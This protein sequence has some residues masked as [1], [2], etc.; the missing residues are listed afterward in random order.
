MFKSFT[1]E[2]SE[3]IRKFTLYYALN[4]LAFPLPIWVIFYLRTI[5]LEQLAFIIGAGQL[6]SIALQIPT[7]ALAD[8]LGRKF[9]ITFG[10]IFRAVSFLLLPF[11]G[12]FVSIFILNG[13]LYVGESMASGAD[14]ALLYDTLK[15]EGRESEFGAIYTKVLLYFRICLIFGSLLG[16]LSYS[17]WYGTPY[18]LRT[19]SLVISAIAVFMMFEPK[20][21]IEKFNLKSYISKTR[22]GMLELVKSSFVK[23]LSLYYIAVG[24]ITFSCLYYFN[25]PFA[26]DFGWSTMQM[27][28]I[29]AVSYIISTGVVYYLTSHK[30]IL[31]RQR[32][33]L[34]FPIL[35][36]IAFLPGMFVGRWIAL[37]LMTISQV[38]GSGRY[39]ILDRYVNLE[40][41]SNHRA[42]AISALNM[43]VGIVMSALIFAGGR[44]QG[45]ADTRMVYTLLGIVSLIVVTPLA[46]IL[47]SDHRRYKAGKL[48]L[49]LPADPVA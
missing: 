48:N 12:S 41:D 27:S 30:S 11:A 18:V 21:V 10:Q 26:Y 4:G 15:E 23:K 28:Y 16:G 22:A 49:V 24:S 34:G 35:M 42:T 45:F 13:I 38:A 36:I 1:Q 29:T 9:M 7:G 32:V 6:I 43:L 31:N 5:S 37:I 39:S 2:K 8:L 44:V 17:L 46:L 14:N 40:F 3:N 19:I 20:R 25:Q 33:Y 47:V